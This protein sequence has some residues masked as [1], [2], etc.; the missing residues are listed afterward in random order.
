MMSIN[1]NCKN[2]LKKKSVEHLVDDALYQVSMTF[3][4]HLH[5]SPDY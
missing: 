4:R 5:L 3:P 1:Y 2:K